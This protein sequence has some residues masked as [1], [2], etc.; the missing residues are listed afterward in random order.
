[1]TQ[2][3]AR[4]VLVDDDPLTLRLVSAMLARPFRSVAQAPSAEA[5]LPLLL[6]T[7]PDL[8]ITDLRMPGIGGVGLLNEVLRQRIVRPERILV[9]TGEP[10]ASTDRK[11]VADRGISVLAKP[12]RRDQ[13]L[14]TVDSLLAS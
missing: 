10:P 4:I 6:E 1:M 2:D 5:A 3:A 13:L 9:I 12:F 14:Q 11:W 7:P 8:L